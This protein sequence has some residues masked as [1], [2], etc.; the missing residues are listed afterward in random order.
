MLF[1]YLGYYAALDIPDYKE[2]AGGT[3]LGSQE[4]AIELIDESNKFLISINTA[5]FGLAGYFINSYREMLRRYTA[6][7]PYVCSL[8]LLSLG[9]V[10]AFR[11]YTELITDLS[12]N[13][14]DI[15]PESSTVLF[16]LRA[17]FVACCSSSITLLSTLAFVL[18][19]QPPMETKNEKNAPS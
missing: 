15:R 12:Q 6:I 18:F 8:L 13:I 9:Y 1:Q 11:A 16:Y 3:L 4:K 19:S 7:I 14:L 17:E 2:I 5:L 10:C